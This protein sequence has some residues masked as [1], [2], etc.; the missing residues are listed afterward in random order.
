MEPIQ[1]LTA[2]SAYDILCQKGLLDNAGEHIKSIIKDGTRAFIVSDT[3]VFPL[4]GERLLNSLRSASIPCFTHIFNAG[5]SSK[6]TTTLVEILNDMA[7]CGLSRSDIVIALGGGV[8]G[9]I[10]GLAAA[11]YERGIRCVQIP[12]TLLAA[13]DSSVGGKTAVNLDAGKNLCGAFHRPSL[14]LFDLNTIKTL[15]SECIG[16]GMAEMI[17][18]GVICDKE[19]FSALANGLPSGDK[20]VSCICRCIQIKIDIVEKDEFEGGVRMLLNYGHTFGHAIEKLSH[21]EISHGHAVAIGSVIA[22][23]SAI[24]LGMCSSDTCERITSALKN[25]SLPTSSPFSAADMYSCMLS[26]KKRRGD[27][28]NLILPNDIGECTIKKL[29]LSELRSLTECLDNE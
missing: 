10:S 7:N 8:V 12:T 6:N 4:Y 28:I 1:K 27:F 2:H 5:E 3:N 29:S 16:D 13:V 9:D 24:K 14:V 26:D 21:Y 17:K 15:P 22:A 23:R 19:L 18:Y 20:L 11:L 25:A